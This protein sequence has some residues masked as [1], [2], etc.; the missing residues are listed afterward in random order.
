VQNSYSVSANRIHHLVDANSLNLF[1]LTR[2]LNKHLAVQVIVV[3]SHILFSFAQEHH[4]IETLLQLLRG[5]MALDNC[6]T[7]LIQT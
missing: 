2:T 7:E 6:K 4:N 5:K 1:C 3:P